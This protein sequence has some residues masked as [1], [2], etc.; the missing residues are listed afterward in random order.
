MHFCEWD[1]F[2]ER[3]STY[4]I[5]QN[6]GKNEQLSGKLELLKVSGV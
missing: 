4:A 6:T 5:G 3:Y 1:E 2:E